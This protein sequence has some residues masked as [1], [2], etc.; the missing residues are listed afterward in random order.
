MKLRL[1]SIIDAQNPMVSILVFLSVGVY[2]KVQ[3]AIVKEI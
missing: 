3:V 1:Q 2:G